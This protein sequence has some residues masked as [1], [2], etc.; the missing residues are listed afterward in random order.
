[1]RVGCVCAC[2]GGGAGMRGMSQRRGGVLV[3]VFISMHVYIPIYA[4]PRHSPAALAHFD[5][6]FRDR[7]RRAGYDAPAEC[8]LCGPEHG[9][10]DTLHHRLWV[11][12]HPSVVA[13]LGRARCPP[14][15]LAAAL[16][17][18]FANPNC[19]FTTGRCIADPSL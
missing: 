5:P 4:Y 1:M 18:D 16:V 12:P 15:A 17:A 10:A 2:G 6:P 11:C 8:K 13:A 7:L 19:A 3:A 14:D 9:H